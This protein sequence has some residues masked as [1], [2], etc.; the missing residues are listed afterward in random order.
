MKV[1]ADYI[2]VTGASVLTNITIQFERKD[3]QFKQKEGVSTASVNIYGRITTMSRRPANWVDEAVQG[4]MQTE[5]R[6]QAAIGS[7]IYKKTLPLKPG[8][9]RLNI[10]AKDVVGGNQTTYE[11]AL[12]VPRMEDDTLSASSLILADVIEK[13]PTKSIG[14]GQFVIGTSKVRPK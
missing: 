3:L 11:M 7:D 9:Y 14:I 6:Q 2:P 13:V 8:R 5:M 12:D 10:A 4:D 1:R